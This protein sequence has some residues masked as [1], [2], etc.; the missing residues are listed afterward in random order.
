MPDP[1][2]AQELAAAAA[3]MRECAEKATAGL[4][5]SSESG[6]VNPHA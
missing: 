6:P 5:T 4:T 3:T 2:P 1:S